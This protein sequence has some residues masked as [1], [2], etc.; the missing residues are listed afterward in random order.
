M[1]QYELTETA[2]E[3]LDYECS[4]CGTEEMPAVIEVNGSN[5]PIVDYQVKVE[6]GDCGSQSYA[7][8]WERDIREAES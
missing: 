4:D 6:C 2:T 8:V 3:E 5:H 7:N 1:T